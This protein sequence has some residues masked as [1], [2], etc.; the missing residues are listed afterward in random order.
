MR[1]AL[2]TLLILRFT[3]SSGQLSI[4]LEAGSDILTGRRS[5]NLYDSLAVGYLKETTGGYFQI[6]AFID[7]KVS[8]KF[9]VTSRVLWQ[10]SSFGYTIQT[11]TRPKN[12]TICN[13]RKALSVGADRISLEM[14]PSYAILSRGNSTVRVFAGLAASYISRDEI[15]EG[16]WPDHP[17]VT[18]MYMSLQEAPKTMIINPVYGVRVDYHRFLISAKYQPYTRLTDKVEFFG[19]KLNLE[20]RWSFASLTVGFKIFEFYGK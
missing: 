18:E 20:S 8:P 15:V 2:L 4:G 6:G 16:N 17:G 7:Y 11:I 1:I 13:P 3:E 12:C 9:F 10:G 5:V 14:I 19:E